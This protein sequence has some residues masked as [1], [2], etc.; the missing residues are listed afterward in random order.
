MAA[1]V[2]VAEKT[3]ASIQDVTALY[4]RYYASVR[5]ELGGAFG[6]RTLLRV[7]G[8][9]SFLR[10]VDRCHLEQMARISKSFGIATEVFWEAAQRLHE[11]EFVDMYEDEVVRI[12][13]Q[14]LATYL[15]YL[16]TFGN[17]G[18]LNVRVLIRDFFP[19]Q[20]YRLTDVVQGVLSA[21]DAEAI[22]AQLRPH[23]QHALIAADE[24]GDENKLLHLVDAFWFTSPTDTLIA[25]QHR[26]AS[27]EIETRSQPLNL[28]PQK[29]KG[30]IER[31]TLL[32]ALGHFRQAGELRRVALDM[33]LELA[34]KRP[35][36]LPH[37]VRYLVERYGFRQSSHQ[38]GYQVEQD[39]VDALV[40]RM[41][42][43]PDELFVHLFCRVAETFLRTRFPISD[44]NDDGIIARYDLKLPGGNDISILRAKIWTRLIKLA[45][46]KHRRL[47]VGVLH[48]HVNGWHEVISPEVVAQ[49]ATHVLP[50]IDADLDPESF[51]DCVLANAYMDF[52]DRR[53][54]AYPVHLRDRFTSEE[55]VLAEL[56]DPGWDKHM[57][58]GYE[59]YSGWWNGRI[60]EHFAT[61]SVEDYMRFF[62]QA[63]TIVDAAADE[64]K[65]LHLRFAVEGVLAELSI[66]D[67]GL[68]VRV[69][70][71][72]LAAGNPLAFG[73]QRL[74]AALTGHLGADGALTVLTA[75]EYFGRRMWLFDYYQTLPPGEITVERLVQLL[76]LFQ[77]AEPWENPND[78][79]FLERYLGVDAHVFVRVAEILVG[80]AEAQPNFGTA[81]KSLFRSHG[82]L[83]NELPR[84]FR[85]REDLIEKAYL[86]MQF[87]Q[88]DSDH[89]GRVFDLLL[90]LNPRFG[91]TYIEW[92]FDHHHA[93]SRPYATPYRASPD[94]DLNHRRY[95]FI[96]KRDD[97]AAIMLEL[98][99]RIFELEASRF[100]LES[101]INVFF[102]VYASDEEGAG[103][104]ASIVRH[105]Q[106][107]VL[108]E[109]I[110]RRAADI[111]FVEWV[112]E[113]VANFSS[114]RRVRLVAKFLACNQNVED[115]K[116]L[117][118]DQ[119]HWS[120]SGSFVPVFQKR[121][122]VL[123]AF[124]P[125]VTRSAFLSHRKRIEDEI[126]QYRDMID[127][128]MR[129]NFMGH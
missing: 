22:S 66:R 121:I 43:D 88:P 5:E 14:V 98:V 115:F 30:S 101:Y 8:I 124:L 32:H 57:E 123:K 56:L 81:L 120:A 51:E 37:I 10:V 118:L 34:A 84:H 36:D 15:F 71:K 95:D 24:A 31:G 29:A 18:L 12:S 78:W 113:L 67:P 68:F 125:L 61:A 11:M 40:E 128:E 13:D 82:A 49:D 63:Q 129:R 75:Y 94:P 7:A 119:K 17:P 62:E 9:I 91:L 58:I 90:T 104:R 47:A 45:R 65:K 108:A 92:V 64:G 76:K 105:R 44:W 110:E 41:E 116:R 79:Q 60:A 46:G 122:E 73:R 52:L 86:L 53:D 69:I 72:Y 102:A 26:I 3:L 6:D 114:E 85:G 126:E 4:D 38:E 107:E 96:W 55:Y 111:D 74:A 20:Y 54:V 109:L 83:T 19:E 89:D 87:E 35:A 39:V 2:V 70:D 27:M 42:R 25:I 93:K 103:S 28:D 80:K 1:C 50:F 16:A 48:S 21:F 23:V 127:D 117:T 77:E 112:F 33:L 106:E 97:Y 100:C 59:N 99:P